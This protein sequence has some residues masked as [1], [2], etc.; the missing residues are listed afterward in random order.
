MR[1]RETQRQQ[2]LETERKSNKFSLCPIL[3]RTV[4]D[5]VVA[6]SSHFVI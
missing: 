3:T 6:C 1:E 4:R 5:K 2:E